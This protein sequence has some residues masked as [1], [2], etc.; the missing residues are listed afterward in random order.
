MSLIT[1]EFLKKKKKNKLV[2]VE[3]ATGGVVKIHKKT[4]APEG[5]F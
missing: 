5:L 1:V 4:P 2:C 3:T